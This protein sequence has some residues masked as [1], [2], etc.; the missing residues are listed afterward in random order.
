MKIGPYK[1]LRKPVQVTN[2]QLQEI[3]DRDLA[4]LIMLDSGSLNVPAEDDQLLSLDD[5]QIKK[6]GDLIAKASLAQK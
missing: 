3:S 1:F 5:E 4:D 6:R 2:L